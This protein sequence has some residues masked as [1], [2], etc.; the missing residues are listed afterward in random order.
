MKREIERKFRI[1]SNE[2]RNAVV[3]EISIRQAYIARGPHLVVRVRL[4]DSDA[5]LTLKTA[6][7]GLVRQE[8][9]YEM[10]RADALMLLT[11][12][13][14]GCVVEKT[15][16][17]IPVSGLVWEIDVFEGYNQGLEVAEVELESEDQAI[18][19]PEWIGAE[20]TGE[21]RFYNSALAERPFSL[22]S[23]KERGGAHV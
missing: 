19:L 4:T 2:W 23:T 14:E 12:P 17:L 16:F 18:E 3:R 5:W 13:V 10:T 6:S 9:E 7:V 8:F 20:I 21:E 22:W 11:G 1:R 15:R